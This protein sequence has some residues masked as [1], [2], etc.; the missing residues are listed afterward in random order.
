MK[1]LL[2]AVL[3]ATTMMMDV[4]MAEA[5]ILPAGPAFAVS[6]GSTFHQTFT[7][8]N[9]F[10]MAIDLNDWP[11]APYPTWEG[12]TDPETF[13]ETMM[14]FSVGAM[15]VEGAYSFT[16]RALDQDF[17]VL[18]ERIYT[19]TVADPAPETPTPAACHM[20]SGQSSRFVFR[21]RNTGVLPC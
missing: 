7:E 16:V 13:Q 6:P 11:S 8:P 20:P 4:G 12:T 5:E 21:P 3:A 17:N 14:D 18:G 10:Y 1:R 2:T 19:I 9:A 15:T